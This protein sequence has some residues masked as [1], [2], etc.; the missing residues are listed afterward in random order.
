[1]EHVQTKSVGET[2][3]PWKTA[4]LADCRATAFLHYF[5]NV[6]STVQISLYE[7]IEENLNLEFYKYSENIYSK[8][9]DL[10]CSMRIS[11]IKRYR[12]S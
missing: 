11:Y 7:G 9:L 10:I 5:L 1:M 4:S 2:F 3:Q 8:S 12:Y 6:K